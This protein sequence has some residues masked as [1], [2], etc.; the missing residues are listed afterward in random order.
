MSSELARPLSRSTERRRASMGPRALAVEAI[1]PLTIVA[2]VVWAIAQPY[3]VA[4]IYRDGKGIY[5]YLFQPPLL[6]VVVG[7]VFGLFV[8]PSLVRDLLEVDERSEG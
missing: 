8:A 1:G 6:V 3:R 7:V 5:D 2:G 4:F